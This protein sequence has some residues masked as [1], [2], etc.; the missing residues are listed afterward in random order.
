MKKPV[1]TFLS[2]A[3]I[4]AFAQGAVAGTV[5]LKCDAEYIGQGGRYR[6]QIIA[7]DADRR[8]V[9]IATRIE[10]YS[11]ITPERFQAFHVTPS[12]LDQYC[13]AGLINGNF[14]F[15]NITFSEA[16]I[17]EMAKQAILCL[18]RWQT[19]LPMV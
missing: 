8:L 2:G 12:F 16:I 17:F 10:G 9:C 14:E 13:V 4:A 7:I 3:L 15:S 1:F 5:V 19:C 18:G 11:T 6:P